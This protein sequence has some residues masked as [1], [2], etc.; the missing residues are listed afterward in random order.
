MVFSFLASA[1]QEGILKGHEGGCG[2][3]SAMPY[4]D[5]ILRETCIFLKTNKIQNKRANWG[6]TTSYKQLWKAPGGPLTLPV[7]NTQLHVG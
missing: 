1:V 2:G 6:S 7:I 4:I 3:V 5:T